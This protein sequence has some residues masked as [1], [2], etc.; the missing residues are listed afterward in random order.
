MNIFHPGEKYKLIFSAH[1]RA[2]TVAGYVCSATRFL[3]NADKI[4][5]KK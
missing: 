4:N 1:P 3:R 2:G 5:E